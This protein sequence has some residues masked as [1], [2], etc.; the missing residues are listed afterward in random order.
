MKLKK[1]SPIFSIEYLLL[2]DTA[3][4]SNLVLNSSLSINIFNLVAY[5]STF[6]KGTKKHE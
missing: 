6:P 5:S 4:I 3:F 1:D 2:S